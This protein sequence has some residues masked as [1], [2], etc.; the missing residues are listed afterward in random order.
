MFKLQPEK[1]S[2][3]WSQFE[4]YIG[5]SLAPTGINDL[6]YRNNVLQAIIRGN[7]DVWLA[8]ENGKAVAVL[9]TCVARDDMAGTRC[10]EIYSLCGIREISPKTYL[11][12]IKILKA[13]AKACKCH[14]IIGYTVL[15]GLMKFIKKLGG[16]A[17]LTLLELEV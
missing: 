3:H 10:L 8:T 12:G 4:H 11:E 9:T 16:K 6:R 15:P 13:Y 1:V 17:R 7:L 2:K 5:E 14:K